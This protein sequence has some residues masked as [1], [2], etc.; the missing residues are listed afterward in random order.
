M[1]PIIWSYEIKDNQCPTE[2]IK[3]FLKFSSFDSLEFTTTES[4]MDLPGHKYKIHSLSMVGDPA[5][6][7]INMAEI[8]N[9]IKSWVLN[10]VDCD[11]SYTTKVYEL[12][13]VVF[14][15]NEFM[16]HH[17]PYNVFYT[18]LKNTFTIISLT[19]ENNAE[20]T[21]QQLNLTEANRLEIQKHLMIRYNYCYAIKEFCLL[22]L[23]KLELSERHVN[24]NENQKDIAK[25]LQLLEVW[26]SLEKI[27]FLD[28][29]TNHLKKAELR[30]SF[31]NIFNCNDDNYKKNRSALI[32]KKNRSANFLRSMVESFE[33]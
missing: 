18:S 5:T 13:H 20:V 8:T 22:A 17:Q 12:K 28:H 26:I 14:L 27:G 31:M 30:N 15:L 24:L 2:N 9:K 4:L 21:I 6:V 32:N 3:R 11:E 23:D 33:N 7:N 1:D 19:D 16:I 29:E 10:Y 25:E